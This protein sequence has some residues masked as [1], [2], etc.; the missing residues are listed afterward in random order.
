[1]ALATLLST[2]TA[3]ALND[4][5]M[6]K[7]DDQLHEA[8]NRAARPLPPPGGPRA[9]A[10]GA[11]DPL[12]FV[13]RGG[14]QIGTLGAVISP[15]GSVSKAT[16]S[17][18]NQDEVGRWSINSKELSAKAMASLESTALDGRPH[19]MHISEVGSYRVRSVHTREG[20]SILVG[21][22]TKSVDNALQRLITVEIALTVAG[23]A[24]AAL[25]SAGLVSGALRPL[26]RVT[27]TAGRVSAL[28]LERGD[29]E[30]AE[31]VPEAEADPRT[32]VGQ[33]GAALNRMLGHVSAALT[34]RQESEV[35]ARQ[36]VADASHELRTPL[37]SIRG[38]AE[39][40]RRFSS[41]QEQE[42]QHALSRIQSEG[43][44]M[45]NLVDELLLLARL[46]TGRPLENA[47]VDLSLMLIDGVSDARAAGPD[48]RWCLELPDEPVVLRGDSARLQQVLNN[49]LANAR[50]HTPPTTTVTTRLK[51]QSGDAVLEVLDDGPGIPAD[52]VPRVFERFVRG[53]T[54]RSRTAG[55]TGLGLAIVQAVAA[56]HH[57]TVNVRSE[58]GHTV[59]CVRL[60]LQQ[61][62]AVEK[63]DASHS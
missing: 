58:P 32:E 12:G 1:M 21:I 49:L 44:R 36:F 28:P 23:V 35:R 61:P 48:H 6:G 47:E 22:P 51:A 41:E 56:A 45:S 37:S 3:V 2:V 5:L 59:F 57:G 34:A 38:Y 15:E 27:A 4:Y 42:M 39:M 17:E 62:I 13:T 53:D 31:R 50:A 43:H 14:Q 18:E 29:V 11:E 20:D 25:A 24:A 63:A 7:L 30:L 8:A 33:V 40:A 9:V 10:T 55:S 60:P 19:S 54:S 46:D 52:L 16:I 26:R